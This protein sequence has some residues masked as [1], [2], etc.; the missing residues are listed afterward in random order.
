MEICHRHG[1]PQ[2]EG[3][4]RVR[5]GDYM[6]ISLVAHA[7]KIPLKIIP[8]RFSEYCECVEILPEEQSG[9]RPN[10]ST[11]ETMFV[12]RQLQELV[13]RN[14][15]RCMYALLTIPKAYDFVD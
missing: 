14:E 6:S 4:D 15:F 2:K 3:S 8:R 7:G 12:I 1:T 10:R 13:L 9:F 5:R 11:T